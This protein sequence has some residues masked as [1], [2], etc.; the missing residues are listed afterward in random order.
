MADAQIPL[1]FQ[2]RPPLPPPNARDR[3]HQ[4]TRRI[5]HPPPS[6]IR[7]QTE[8]QQRCAQDSDTAEYDQ[9]GCEGWAREGQVCPG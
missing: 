8:R 1:H 7:F 3:T 9:G 6:R 2:H 4:I 5:R